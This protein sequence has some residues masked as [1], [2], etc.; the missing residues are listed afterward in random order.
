MSPARHPEWHQA[1]NEQPAIGRVALEHLPGV[2][3]LIAV[4]L[5]EHHIDIAEDRLEVALR[6]VIAA[7]H[8]GFLLGMWLDGGCVG[9]AYVSL[10]WT[11]EHGGHSAWL[12]EFYVDPGLRGRGHGTALLRAV[13]AECRAHGCAAIDLEIDSGNERV[14]TLY[15]RH[16]FSALTRRRLVKPLGA[17]LE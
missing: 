1:L 4:Q 17:D 9:V 11:L 3:R 12:E 14:R 6:G 16:G 15:Q 7:P 10:V 8:R 5:R 13:E 2:L